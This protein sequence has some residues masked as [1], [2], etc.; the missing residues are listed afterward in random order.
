MQCGWATHVILASPCYLVTPP[1]QA[2]ER[3]GDAA[4]QNDQPERA[5]VTLTL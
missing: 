4:M 3:L 1:E 5:N 2:H